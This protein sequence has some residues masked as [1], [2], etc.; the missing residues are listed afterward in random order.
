[1][2]EAAEENQETP[3]TISQEKYNEALAE[4]E[5]LRGHSEKLLSETKEA[6]TAAKQAEEKRRLEAE[7]MARRAGDVDAI[8]KSYDEKIERITQD[9]TGQLDESKQLLRQATVNAT[10]IALASEIAV[11]GSQEA[12]LPHIEKRLDMAVR[13]GKAVTQV[14]DLE[15]KPSV[16]TVEELKQ[17]FINNPVFAPLVI[18]SKA[19]G[20]GAQGSNSG[21][22]NKTMK[23]A[24][25][26][27]IAPRDQV[28]F[29]KDGGKVID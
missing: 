21:A 5:R 6:K 8:S 13:E 16:Q 15:G 4:I 24:D 19:S 17:E 20:G 26:M 3:E 9:F 27:N 2:T 10:A 23:R 11:Q 1:M 18:G 22:G 25:F 28:A 12:L 14:L 29:M 7:D